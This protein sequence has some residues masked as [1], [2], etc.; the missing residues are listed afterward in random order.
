LVPGGLATQRPRTKTNAVY[1]ER[2][3][4]DRAYHRDQPNES[5]PKNGGPGVAFV[6]DNVTGSDD[7]NE[8]RQD[9]RNVRPDVLKKI[10]RSH[11]LACRSA[12]QIAHAG[13]E[14]ATDAG[15]FEQVLCEVNAIGFEECDRLGPAEFEITLF[16]AFMHRNPGTNVYSKLPT[17]VA[18]TSNMSTSPNSGLWIFV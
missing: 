12:H 17:Q 3:I 1:A 2:E 4:S 13:V 10:Q 16:V 15:V 5:D 11:T 14:F 6:E 18:P 7:G 8:D 9:H